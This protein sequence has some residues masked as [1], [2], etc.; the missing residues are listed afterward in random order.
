MGNVFAQCQHLSIE[1]CK[2]C[3]EV[4]PHIRRGQ[5]PSAA[6]G[7]C[8][9]GAVNR[10]RGGNATPAWWPTTATAGS[11]SQFL[12]QNQ[13]PR[14]ASQAR[15]AAGGGSFQRLVDDSANL[16]ALQEA[17]LAS[18]A[19][20]PGG[21]MPSQPRTEDEIMAQIAHNLQLE[22][23]SRERAQLREEQESEYQESLRI[24][25][26]KKEEKQQKE[27]EA[28]QKLRQEEQ[29]KQAEDDAKAAADQE[30]K[31]RRARGM[32]LVEEARARLSE[33][34]SKG[35]LGCITLLVRTPE[36]KAL[37][38]G[39][40]SADAVSHIYDYV[41]VEGGETLSLQ[42]F[43]LIATMPRRVFEDRAASLEAAGL[44]DQCALF[45]EV[46][47]SDQLN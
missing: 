34:P 26:Q 38:R 14:G 44:Q 25:Q 15:P 30:E 16:A 33:E 28:E 4:L 39:F 47:K 36:G 5:S 29:Q 24:D 37:K 32:A 9:Q 18:A 43:R 3:T 19:A 12:P 21:G 42:E 11:N 27:H 20:M 2:D 7:A 23:D 6:N 45:V 41:V 17:I 22:E 46:I 31:D 10:D 1:H 8:S 40:R 35:E 13:Q